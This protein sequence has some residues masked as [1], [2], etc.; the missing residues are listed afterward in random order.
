MVNL[1][2]INNDLEKIIEI[3]YNKIREIINIINQYYFQNHNN[4][5]LNVDEEPKKVDLLKRERDPENSILKMNNDSIFP[6]EI[7]NSISNRNKIIT[8]TK[9]EN[10]LRNFRD[11]SNLY[12]II[13]NEIIIV[14]I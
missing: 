1:N 5:S 8:N 9:Q 12:P 2:K 4:L 14:L 6:K 13:L 3:N 11:E 7:Y 10:E